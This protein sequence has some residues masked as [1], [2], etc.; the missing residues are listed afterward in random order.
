[1][2]GDLEGASSQAVIAAVIMKIADMESLIEEVT[3]A[4]YVCLLNYINIQL[5]NYIKTS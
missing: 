1:M 4:A 2:S 5:Y 3:D